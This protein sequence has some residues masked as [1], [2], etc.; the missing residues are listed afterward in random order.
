M[1]LSWLPAVCFLLASLLTS[2]ASAQSFAP[3]PGKTPDA[4]T[5]EQ[6]ATKSRRLS[7]MLGSLRRQGL[8]DPLL[9]DLEVYYQAARKIVQHDEFFRPEYGNWTLEALDRGLLRASLVAQGQSPWPHSKGF[10]VVRG[11]RS[12]IDG[13]VQPYAVT[14]PK[15]YGKEAGKKWRIDV[16]L[17]GRDR[18]LNEV[19]FLHRHNG[20]QPATNED[21][22]QIDIFG[23][24]NVAYRWAGETDVFEALNNFFVVETTFNRNRLLDR[25]R[26][27]LRG[28]SMGGAGT[29]H[30][31]LHRPDRWCVIGPGA[32]FTTTHGYVKNLPAK[33]PWYQEKCLR[34]YDAVDY[35][36]NCFDVPV[37]AYSGE[38]DAQRQAAVN[39]ENRLKKL[40]LG[41]KMVHLV[42]PGEKHR[43]PAD[44]RKK[45]EKLYAKFARA[46]RPD[47][48]SQIR[49]ETYTLRYASCF[50]VEI[51][52]LD[53]HYERAVI[54]ANADK[55]EVKTKNIR[56][57][58]LTLPVGAPQE[59]VI[60]IDGQKVNVRPWIQ[61]NGSYYAYFLKR[62]GKWKSVLPQR[63]TTMQARR[64]QKTP[65]LQG[66]IDDAFMER[67]VCVRGTG[68]AWHETTQQYA[69]ADLQRFETEWS[70]YLRGN[71]PIKAD[72]DVDSADI[73]S[74]NLILFGDPSSNSLIAQVLDG[75]PLKWSKDSIQFAGK[76]YDA[77]N[78]VPVMI[79]PSP[80]NTARYVVINSGHTFHASDFRGTN[81]LLYPRLGDY[82][83]LRLQGKK[84]DLLA[85][86]VATAGLFNDNWAIPERQPTS[87]E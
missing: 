53:Q 7:K 21:F 2:N 28:F 74:K 16:V 11:Y 84:E 10:A 73:S 34:I 35:S 76:T 63:I 70:K 33:L 66:P 9:A 85:V 62:D 65:G 40:G 12:A 71:L 43:F 77:K 39:I 69:E 27:V 49:F 52:G 29:W 48:P 42:A 41:D 22:I 14:L 6:I 3:P 82:A 59:A 13:S 5:L 1:K 87:A 47:Y 8:H 18:T 30:I 46:G 68:K 17:H 83:V 80:L 50:W 67:F 58:R 24:G 45:A 60:K 51:L 86:D 31:G 44:W 36:L 75:L 20:D 79:F 38:L 72:I 56:A 54:E 26:V 37:V 25:D 61:P 19:K 57:F 81:A 55:S 4:K 32:G 15:D 23:R 64:L 78:H